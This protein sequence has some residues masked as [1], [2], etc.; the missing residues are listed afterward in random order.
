MARVFF[1][2][3]DKP[4]H[5]SIIQV[6]QE[7][8]RCDDSGAE[9]VNETSMQSDLVMED[10]SFMM[11]DDMQASDTPDGEEIVK[12]HWSKNC[13]RSECSDLKM[14]Y[15]ATEF[16]E[17]ADGPALLFGQLKQDITN[18]RT[19]IMRLITL[20]V[21]SMYHSGICRTANALN[22]GTHYNLRGD[23]DPEI[24]G[25][26]VNLTYRYQSVR[27][28]YNIHTGRAT[29]L[30]ACSEESFEYYARALEGRKMPA[31]RRAHPFSI[32]LILLF[33]SV[34]ERNQELEESLRKLLLL[35]DRS[36]FRKTKVTFETADDT[37]R[38]LQD[39]HSLFKDVLIRENNNK[40]QIATIDCLIRDLDRLRTTVKQTDGAF[41]IDEHDHQRIIDGF[42][43]LKDFCQDRERRL[44]GR[45][46][47]VQNLIALTYNLLANRDSIT[48]HSIA[49]DARQDGAAMKTIAMVTMLFFPATFVSSFLGTNLVS[50]D[51]GGDGRTRFVFSDL[52]W[53]Y[54]VAAV[55]LTL[56]TLSIYV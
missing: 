9:L 15:E 13:D 24:S 29:Y 44:K 54:L 34:L 56:V 23:R 50:L 52:W 49:H 51:T 48:S 27:F 19:R 11:F 41:P 1:E 28:L 21:E 46:Q 40:R 12:I 47:R 26:T 38:R 53:I 43:C 3:H 32:H 33:K 4:S 17:K 6:T 5:D 55:P 14:Q 18:E 2:P 35:E 20:Q 25:G 10:L 31:G 39:L 8:E 37:K 7:E 22:F 45:S 30:L 36:I 16:L 42:H